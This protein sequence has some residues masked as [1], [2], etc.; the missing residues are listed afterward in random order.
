MFCGKFPF[1]VSFT[2]ATNTVVVVVA[3]GF[4]ERLALLA[5]YVS[6]LCGNARIRGAMLNKEEV[7]CLIWMLKEVILGKNNMGMLAK[8]KAYFCENVI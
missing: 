2:A 8:C 1:K 3:S 5:L 6:V 4:R 7:G